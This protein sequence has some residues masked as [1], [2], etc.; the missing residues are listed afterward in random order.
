MISEIVIFWW[1]NDFL[2]SGNDFL[3]SEIPEDF[4][5]SENDFGIS[6]KSSDIIKSIS[7]TS[8]THFW[9][10]IRTSRTPVFWEYPRR[11]MI[12]HTIESYWIPGQKMAKSK[13][14]I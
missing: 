9:Y 6:K 12:T 14:Q 11:L 1:E 3:I 10:K 8:R 13:L 7:E 4:L 2:V 5:I